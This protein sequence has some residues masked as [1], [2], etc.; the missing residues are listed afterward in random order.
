[1]NVFLKQPAKSNEPNSERSETERLHFATDTESNSL[2]SQPIEADVD[3]IAG[4]LKDRRSRV[5]NGLTYWAWRVSTPILALCF[6][7]TLFFIPSGSLPWALSFLFALSTVRAMG[8]LSESVRI[9]RAALQN[10]HIGKEWIGALCEALEW[11]DKQV[12]GSAA[13]LLT[14]LLPRLTEADGKLLN[15]EQLNCL[16][17]RLSPSK[18]AG[19]PELA[20]VILRLL[21]FLGTEDALSYVERL[22]CLGSFTQK[23][24][25]L[26]SGAR[27][28]HALL[29]RRVLVQ[30]AEMSERPSSIPAVLEMRANQGEFECT[31][32]ERTELTEVTVQLDKE[33]AKFEAELKRLQ[34]P[35]M[36]I[37][38]LIATW[39]VVFP[40]GA[41]QT[42]FQFLNGNWIGGSIF[43]ILTVLSTQFHRLTLMGQH[44][45]LARR[46]AKI[47]DVRCI[48]RLAEVLEWP[49]SA[50]QQVAISS[51]SQL[52]PQVKASD[53]VFQTARQRAN[54]HRMLTL[55]NARR[56]ARFLVN[57]LK[58]LEQIGDES[59]MPYVQQLAK[60]APTST[61]QRRVCDAA[62]ECLPYL[63]LRVDLNRNSQTLLRASSAFSV[64]SDMLVRPASAS[65]ATDRDQLLRPGSSGIEI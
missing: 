50:V 47:E 34:V 5:R 3:A 40:Y 35:G 65:G 48:G 32:Q 6:V 29:E 8:R 64:G 52:L 11:P 63:E 31:E 17:R 33:L 26:R 19:N 20:S 18:A 43:A 22:A 62:R 14:E 49:D 59:A 12:Q 38:F 24:R 57:L 9:E 54:L 23:G 56:H 51:L 7:Y 30:R 45:L 42:V 15:E 41:F 13:L 55:P 16:Y 28:V 44:K 53:K 2:S 61:Q 10:S 46:L 27:A 1:M 36:R 60:A 37:G 39:C 25:R 58:A 21:P 4:K